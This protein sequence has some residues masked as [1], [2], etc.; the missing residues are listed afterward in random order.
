MYRHCLFCQADLGSNELI[1]TLPIGRRV[2]FDEAKGRLW[3][4]CRKCERWNLTP[5][6]TRFEAIETCERAFR[7]TKLRVSTDNIGLAR[8]SEGLELVRIGA[9][10]RPEMAAWRYGD[11]FGRRKKRY[12]YIAGGA[13]A[14][15]VA[16]QAGLSALGLGVGAFVGMSGGMYQGM[17]DRIARVKVSAADGRVVH[18][19][20]SAARKA[21]LSFDTYRNRLELSVK[22]GT[23]IERWCDD[24]ARA[25]AS[26]V[27]PRAN[28]SGG[29]KTDVRDA[30]SMVAAAASQD[31]IMDVLGTARI[32]TG[33]PL[34]LDT[35]SLPRRLAL[36][37]SLHEEQERR[38][39]HGELKELELRWRAAEEI[40]AIADSLTIPASVE[41]RFAA[42]RPRDK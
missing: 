42:L 2:A 33:R 41:E 29:G 4:V 31:P 40:A 11:Q 7:A 1:E 24:D 5:F 9:P 32:R 13:V 23:R 18:L 15:L 34:N 12:A 17:V 38:A 8:I 30:V 6:D 21:E 26:I 16:V 27:L 28:I 36:E 14:G 22:S 20:P 10:M 39:L 37:M 35:L 25:M 19:V 3:V